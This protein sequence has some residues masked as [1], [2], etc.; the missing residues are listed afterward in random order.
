[1]RFVRTKI[2]KQG[3]SSSNF[4]TPKSQIILRLTAKEQLNSLSQSNLAHWIP[5]QGPSCLQVKAKKSFG[6][7]KTLLEGSTSTFW[8]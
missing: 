3:T 2:Q 4:D 7:Q 1:M 8:I 5:L 6:S